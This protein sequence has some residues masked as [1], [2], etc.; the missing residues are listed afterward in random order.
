[1]FN[2]L[3]GYFLSY[4]ED[5]DIVN[6]GVKALAEELSY[7]TIIDAGRVL[8]KSN[9]V[10]NAAYFRL[11]CLHLSAYGYILWGKEFF[12]AIKTYLG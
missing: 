11:D 10:A 7:V 2:R 1:L 4:S 9:G 12:N 8:L 6:E 3:P 5:I